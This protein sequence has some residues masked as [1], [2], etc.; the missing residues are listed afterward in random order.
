M[1]SQTSDDIRARGERLW[2][3]RFLPYRTPKRLRAVFELG[4][5]IVPL[6]ALWALSWL[7]LANGMWWALL[8]T[9][10][11]AAGFLLRL[12]MVQHDCGHG[13]F[14]GKRSVDDWIG[15]AIG[16]L[17]FTPYD[18]WRRSHS[19][20][21]A[22]SGNLDARGIGDVMTLTVSEYQALPYWNRVGYWLYR[23]PAVM[24]GLGPIWLFMIQ[25]RLPVGDMRGTVPWVSVMGTNAA[26]AVLALVLIWLVGVVPFLLIQLPIVL[27]AAIG[28]VWLFYVQHQFENTYWSDGKEWDFE[29]A[30]L[31]GSSYYDL[32][33]PLRWLTANIG[34]HHVHHI[35]SKV[36]Y[37]RLPEV[38]RD[39]PELKQIGR[40]TFWQ[41]LG[42]VRLVLWD[43]AKK[44][45][46]TFRE[47]RSLAPAAV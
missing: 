32:P 44:R 12:F 40:V 45:L 30:A 42:G 17:T 13:A 23:N 15:R 39:Y 29:R 8:L 35:S 18:Y 3:K 14:F 16:V 4:T 26:I 27:L 36:P 2:L 43:E 47:A 25:H 7:A 24:F 34:V 41:S 22:S 21:H 11:A 6:V 20:H 33:A 38:L 28:G 10:P 9:V 19:I 46:V 1:T 31:R 5:T 37:Y